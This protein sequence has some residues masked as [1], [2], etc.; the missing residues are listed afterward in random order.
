MPRHKGH[1]RGGGSHGGRGKGGAQLS[2]S[3]FSA[4]GFSP[5]TA[6]EG[7]LAEATADDVAN[8]MLP[9]LERMTKHAST[10]LVGNLYDNHSTFI[11]ISLHIEELRTA[12]ATLRSSLSGF[13][14]ALDDVAASFPDLAEPHDAAAAALRRH[15]ARGAAAGLLPEL[16]ALL[17]LPDELEAL[18]AER[19][20]ADA[21]EKVLA[22]R[23]PPAA[24]SPVYPYIKDRID[25]VAVQL[26]AALVD[27]ASPDAVPLLV[28][29]GEIARAQRVLLAAAD[30]ELAAALACIRFSGNLVGYVRAL[31]GEVFGAVARTAERYHAAFTHPHAASALLAWAT[32]Q[33]TDFAASFERLV[34]SA[35]EYAVIAQCMEVALD[36]A[37]ADADCGLSLE[38]FLHSALGKALETLVE[39]VLDKAKPVLDAYVA[40]EKWNSREMRVMEG[41]SSTVVKLSESAKYVY[42][43]LSKFVSDV[44]AVVRPSLCGCV[45]GSIVSFVESY[46]ATLARALS[47]PEASGSA[48]WAT[49]KQAFVMMGNVASLGFELVPK[50]TSRLAALFGADRVSLLLALATRL[51]AAVDELVD[52]FAAV[53]ASFLLSSK[54]GWAS[55]VA[56]YTTSTVSHADAE[57]SRAM[58]QLFVYLAKMGLA[59]EAHLDGEMASSMEFATGPRTFGF[60][61]LQQFVLD[62]RFFAAAVA[63]REPEVA[64]RVAGHVEAAVSAA[65]ASYAASSGN[66]PSDVLKSTSWFND[67]VGAGLDGLRRHGWVR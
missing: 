8:S 25:A 58:S 27:D 7:V 50:L 67:R 35:S 61:G 12:S 43:C 66:D 34:F 54:L 3:A 57:P 23:A 19:R 11:G 15:D 55:D 65:V 48:R 53:R 14:H 1:E 41:E 64:D 33:V 59:L 51:Q 20:L 17:A 44:S 52:A 4:K 47:S 56:A 37:R 24:A 10:S 38:F 28:R 42:L 2:F 6:A 39:A 46:V 18:L 31:A 22:A 36:A 13:S 9:A 21:V 62:L 45:V 26:V 16:A 49:D 60:G 5:Q 30:A 29:L 40:S 32:H 63:L